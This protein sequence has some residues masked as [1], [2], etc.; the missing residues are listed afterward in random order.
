MWRRF[1]T[2]LTVFIVVVVG[3]PALLVVCS[4]AGLDA[5]QPL[6]AI[7]STEEIRAYFERR[8][9]PTEV[10]PMA[11]RVL[12]AVGW[13]LWLAMV[14]SV[15]ASIFEARGSTLRSWVP[16]FAMFRGLGQWIA[17]GLTAIS[18]LAPNFVS[19]ATLASPRPF[20]I[21]SIT[22]DSVVAEPA[23]APGF[24]RV[25][26]GE[27]IETFAQRLLGD[28][29]RWPELWELNKEQPVGPGGEI[30]SAPWKLGAGSDLRLPP[31]ATPGVHSMAI[32]GRRE[33]H[34]PAVA[35]SPW[36]SRDHLTVVDEYEVV[37]GDSYWGIAERFLSDESTEHDVWEFT[38]ALM[39]F[40]APRL[41][42]AHPAMLHP[43]DVVEIVAAGTRPAADGEDPRRPVA[44]GC[45][46]GLLLGDR[47]TSTRGRRGPG[48]GARPDQ[49]VDRGQQPAARLRGPPDDP[50]GRC[51]PHRRAGP[52]RRATIES[53]RA[54]HR[55]DERRRCPRHRRVATVADEPADNGV[56]ATLVVDDS[57]PARPTTADRRSSS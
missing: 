57:T 36:T 51:G 54:G 39:T 50:P 42:Y 19:A 47:R 12:L 27:S 22:P 31:D 4:R 40:N 38:Q 11:L 15:L 8:L 24:G 35:A 26:R 7:G 23:V 17:A 1:W 44:R 5:S 43:G 33:R 25:Q 49:R 13:A 9:T 30:W 16:Q 41:G 3:V 52:N 56:A 34:P 2:A 32:T 53:N 46:R 6:P 45:R 10:A 28:A 21:S 14:L 29:G 20:T 18:S 37:D 55:C 48:C